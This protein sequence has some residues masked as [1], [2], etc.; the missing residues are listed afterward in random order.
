MGAISWRGL[1][2]LVTLHGKVKAAHYVNI[3]GDQAWRF[4]RFQV[5]QLCFSCGFKKRS[6]TSRIKQRSSFDQVSE[7]D[8]GWIVDYRECG[9][10]F[11]EISSRVDETKKL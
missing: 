6:V 8:R 11:R 9:L 5:P 4:R 10:S 3:L 7:F 1:R 2:P